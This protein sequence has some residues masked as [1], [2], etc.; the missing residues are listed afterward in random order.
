MLF[1]YSII[2]YVIAAIITAGKLVD[3]G[4]IILMWRCDDDTDAYCYHRI[5]SIL[6]IFVSFISIIVTVSI[7][8]R[9]L[10]I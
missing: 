7:M 8:K 4:F 5:I 10:F 1:I 9:V 2:T 6:D 3:L